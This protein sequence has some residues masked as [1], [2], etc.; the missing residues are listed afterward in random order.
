MKSSKITT[1]P[2]ANKA[3]KTRSVTRAKKTPAGTPP[4]SHPSGVWIAEDELTRLRDS[5]REAQEAFKACRSEQVGAE[6]PYRIYVE[7]MREGAV[8]VAGDGTV[9]YCNQQFADMMQLPLARVI[10]SRLSGHLTLDAWKKIARVFAFPDE[11]IKHEAVLLQAKGEVLPVYLT[12]SRLPLDGQK[13]MCLVVTDL[14]EQKKHGELRLAKELAE[15]ANLAKDDFIAALSHELRTPL[16]PVLMAATALEQNSVLPADTRESLAMIRR[17]VEL[18]ARL[19]DDLLDLTRIARSRLELNMCEM[20]VQAIIESALEICR[21]EFSARFQK[22]TLEFNAAQHSGLGDPIRIQQAL[23]NLIRNAVKFTDPNGS[24][25]IRTSNPAPARLLVEILDTGMGFEREKQEKLFQAFE[26]GGRQINQKYGG[27][28]LGLA[29]TRSIIEAHGGAIRAASQG[30][31]KGATFAFEIPLR[32]A[33]ATGGETSPT[34]PE[35]SQQ[36]PG[37]R[38]LLVEDHD[39]TRTSLE[40]LL[41]KN[42]HEVKAA[43]TVAEALRL[44][45]TNTFDLVI[46]DIGLPDQSGLVLMRQLRDEFG[47]KGISLSG[48]GME[49]DIAKNRDAG[50]SHHFTKP[51]SFERLNKMIAEI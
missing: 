9:V 24:I 31:G 40:F 38:I 25:L 29:I 46:S 23:W 30:R 3:P 27:L 28:G 39:D 26:Q 10:G 20:D 49:E 8:T 47:L 16:T 15:R 51:V 12:A 22:V 48:Y 35:S 43:A 1:E 32:S 44:A 45:G 13:V 19:I 2:A 18:E 21:S 36:F 14:T 11:V 42:Q 33:V 7:Q 34:L 4:D 17:N 37:K 6:Q 41:R 5:L 50:F